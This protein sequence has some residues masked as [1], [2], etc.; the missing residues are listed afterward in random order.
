MRHGSVSSFLTVIVCVNVNR[1]HHT[2]YI[3][4]PPKNPLPKSE[5]KGL[6][7]LAPQLNDRRIQRWLRGK[8]ATQIS[9]LRAWPSIPTFRDPQSAGP[10]APPFRLIL[11]RAPISPALL[12][13]SRWSAPLN[14]SSSFCWNPPNFRQLYL[15]VSANCAQQCSPWSGLLQPREFPSH[16]RRLPNVALML[17]QRRR[18]WPNIETILGERLVFLGSL[19]TR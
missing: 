12:Y 15:A 16:T 5:A 8:E 18:Q 6:H 9:L 4:A 13:P 3:K 1:C 17:G 7:L 10:T 19:Q 14:L 2:I 11:I